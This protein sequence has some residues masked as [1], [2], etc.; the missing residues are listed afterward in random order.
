MKSSVHDAESASVY[1]KNWLDW[2]GISHNDLVVHEDLALSVDVKWPGHHRTLVADVADD[3]R[4]LSHPDLSLPLNMDD[5]NDQCHIL[6][7]K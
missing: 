1:L 7:V 5:F 3:M 4:Q 6:V 2:S